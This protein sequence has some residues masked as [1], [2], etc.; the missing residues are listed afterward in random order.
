MFKPI[1]RINK[2]H[3]RSFPFVCICISSP[4]LL[5][6]LVSFDVA[7]S[8]PLLGNLKISNALLVNYLSG[9]THSNLYYYQVTII[10]SRRPS[11]TIW[12]PLLRLLPSFAHRGQF[13]FTVD[14][15][16]L[17]FYC[18]CISKLQSYLYNL[19]LL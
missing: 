11:L 8:G 14:F 18:P 10:R 3:V 15:S 17:R 6:F 2:S 4:H 1:W 13:G 19:H 12:L 7:I 16:F 9:V 5:H